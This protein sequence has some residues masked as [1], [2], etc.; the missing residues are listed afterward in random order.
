[1]K[2]MLDVIGDLRIAFWL[3]LAASLVMWIGS[4]IAAG[5]YP[6][7]DSM[8]GVRVQEWL[9]DNG[10]DNIGSVWWIPLLFLIFLLL[11]IN[12]LACT[13][14]RILVLLPARKETAPKDFLVAM[15]PSIIH[16][17]FMFMLS[18]HLLGFTAVEYEKAP[19]VPGEKVTLRGAGTFDVLSVTHEFFP[20][21]SLLR[22]RI[23]QT[24][25]KIGF[26][27]NGGHAEGTLEFMRP[28]YH[29]GYI[30]Q[31]DM[32]RKKKAEM[33]VMKKA[34]PETCNRAGHFH[35][36]ETKQAV[37]PRLYIAATRDPGLYVLIPGFAAVILL[38]GWYFYQ[39]APGAGR[40][41]G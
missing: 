16:L 3:L 9:L 32:E 1:M 7:I 25:V 8:N 22:D 38:M 13:A 14:R 26:P 39:T 5:N 10:R 30:L 27:Q 34:D 40:K 12:T 23:R 28:L 21:D 18:G 19:L 11:G 36:S 17:L 37:P 24:R 15:S 4:L 33:A 35:F 20:G 6:L 31:L 41:T 2:R 29:G